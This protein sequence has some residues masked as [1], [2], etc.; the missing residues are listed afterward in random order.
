MLSVVEKLS[1]GDFDCM[2][3]ICD[4]WIKQAKSSD[5]LEFN[6][7]G[8]I[9]C[10]VTM[11]CS[12]STVV[13]GLIIKSNQSHLYTQDL[14]IESCRALIIK[15]SITY[16]YVHL[17]YTENISVTVKK[18]AEQLQI[19]TKE[20]W[21]RKCCDL[22]SELE[23]NCLLVTGDV[24]TDLESF[25]SANSILLLPGI[26]WTHLQDLCISVNEFPCTY[27]LDCDQENI[28]SNLIVKKWNFDYNESLSDTLYVHID[29]M[30]IKGK[31]KLYT[32]MLCHP[33]QFLLNSQE[34]QFWHLASRLHSATKNN[35]LLPGGG[36]TEKWCFDLLQ[37][38]PSENEIKDRIRVAIS[39]GF[40]S[41]SQMISNKNIRE[42]I[43][44]ALDEMQ[45][46]VQAWRSAMALV[47]TVMQCDFF[48]FKWL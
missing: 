17:G 13:D 3:L 42:E 45:S 48:D 21:I 16:E 22:L 4:I 41:Y 46:K 5:C 30:N 9:I 47:L 18:S 43:C 23:V 28:I 25:C 34:H 39:K 44:N 24:E 31:N 6:I 10:P 12:Y 19:S 33:N 26:S 37:K 36:K 2:N 27:L 32:V 38:S 7:N 15:G 40:L 8:I 35:I 1:H 20:L 29:F 14:N 11:H